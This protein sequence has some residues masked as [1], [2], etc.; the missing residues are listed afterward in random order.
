[1]NGVGQFRAGQFIAQF[2]ARHI[3]LL[4]GFEYRQRAADN[5][6]WAIWGWKI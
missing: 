5:M 6:G 1:M 3:R 2:I 4:I